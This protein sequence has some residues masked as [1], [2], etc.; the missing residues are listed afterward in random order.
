MTLIS[1]RVPQALRD[2][3]ERIAKADSRSLANFVRLVLEQE[4]KRRKERS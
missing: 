4:V 2:E 3:L 1:V